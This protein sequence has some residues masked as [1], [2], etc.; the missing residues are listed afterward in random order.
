MPLKRLSNNSLIKI[1]FNSNHT[2]YCIRQLHLHLILVLKQRFLELQFFILFLFLLGNTPAQLYSPQSSNIKVWNSEDGLPQNSVNTILKS[3][4]GTLWIGTYGGVATFD[5]IEFK[6]LP[7][8]E[9]EYERVISLLEGKDSSMWLGTENNGLYHLKK[10]QLTHI[11]VA[12]GLPGS[13]IVD[14][15]Q[16]SQDSIIAVV[17]NQGPVLISNNIF[18]FYPHKE[19]TNELI[20]QVI[21]DNQNHLWLTG[22]TGVYRLKSIDSKL[23]FISG[24]WAHSDGRAIAMTGNGE[25]YHACSRGLFKINPDSLSQKY[26][27]AVPSNFLSKQLLIQDSI[28]W[29]GGG[30]AHIEKSNQNDTIIWTKANG[31]PNGEISTFYVSE[32]QLWLGFNGGGLG[33]IVANPITNF[34]KKDGLQDELILPI[35]QDYQQNLWVG[36]NAGELYWKPLGGEFSAYKNQGTPPPFDVWSLASDNKGNIW[37]GTFGEGVFTCNVHNQPNFIPTKDWGGESTVILA[38][39]YDTLND[40]LLIGSDMGGVF[41]WKN[42]SWTTIISDEVTQARITQFVISPSQKIFVT[43]EGDGYKVI[44]KDHSI[45]AISKINELT[46]ISIRDIC[47]GRDGSLWIGTYGKGLILKKDGKYYQIE[48]EDGLFDN[49]ISTINIDQNGF[50]WMSCNRGV[51]RVHKEEIYNLLEHKITRINSQVFNTSHGMGHSETNGGFQPS[52]LVQNGN[53]ILYPTL[54]GIARFETDKIKPENQ[55]KHVQI[56]SISF[57]DTNIYNKGNAVVPANFRDVRFNFSAPTFFAPELVT[58]E[59]QLKG[60]DTKWKNSGNTRFVTYTRLAPGNYTFLVRARNSDGELSEQTAQYEVYIT[61]FWYEVIGFRILGIALLIAGII[62]LFWNR[63]KQA[64]KREIELQKLVQK[65]TFQLQKEKE[66]TEK[67]LQTVESQSKELENLNTIKDQ[68]FAIISHDLR[69]SIGAFVGL[70]SL[71]KWNVKKQSLDKLNDLALTVDDEANKLNGFLNNLLSWSSTQLNNTPYH[72]EKTN[73]QHAIKQVINR[74]SFRLGTKSLH[75]TINSDPGHWAFADPNS[76]DLILR[77]LLSNAIKFSHENGEIIFSSTRIENQIQ[78]CIED[79]GMGMD[80]KTLH[81]L[82]TLKTIQSQKGTKGEQG[83]GLGLVLVKEIVTLN[84]GSISVES[85][86]G[87]GSKFCLQ[88]PV[89]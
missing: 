9:L 41:E 84:L 22:S 35:H 60:Y 53:T 86:L 87:K 2:Y 32:D 54:K 30:V 24:S 26:A 3:S 42:N 62:F 13:G 48:T 70:G 71:I 52:S 61:P 4:T 55:L 46:N 29:I 68:F 44:N 12:D 82:F 33:Q 58:Y 64:I 34:N 18:T 8:P 31:L 11:T 67:A 21:L 51:F 49:L 16:I 17:Q 39:H 56:T 75:V 7:Y 45:S 88:L 57:S 83:S 1:S 23:E 38:M 76:L 89:E 50:I 19:F 63:Q 27:G 14:L 43:T 5:G 81:S 77:N 25:L 59:Y 28:F 47:F 37:A 78:I 74:H 65:R 15:L 69:N 6:R 10:G 80:S 73:I 85:N 66:I 36:T 72:P 79:F 20:D 40:R